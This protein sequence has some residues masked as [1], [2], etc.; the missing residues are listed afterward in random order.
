M[1]GRYTVSLSAKSFANNSQLCSVFGWFWHLSFMKGFHSSLQ[2]HAP[3]D[4]T[5]GLIDRYNGHVLIEVLQCN[6][7]SRG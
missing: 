6:L 1:S 3:Y 5:S 7:T 4:K 2:C